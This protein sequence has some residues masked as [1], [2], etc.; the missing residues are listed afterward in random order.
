[1]ISKCDLMA[2][3]KADESKAKQFREEESNNRLIGKC[4]RRK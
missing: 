3:H 4:G 2:S 1:M